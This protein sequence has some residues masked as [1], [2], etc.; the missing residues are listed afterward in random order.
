MEKK[1]SIWNYNP[2][3]TLFGFGNFNRTILGR[4][5]FSSRTSQFSF[6]S[7]G[8]TLIELVIVV[9]ILGVLAGLLVFVVNPG[10]QFAKA[11]D[12]QR[13]HDLDQVRNA[14]DTYYNDNNSYPL[15]Q[16]LGDCIIAGNAWGSSW[17]PYI[18]K[19]PKDPLS[20]RSYCYETSANGSYFWLFATLE[21]CSDFQGAIGVD[22]QR[23]GP[24]MQNYSINSSNIA[25][26]AP[27]P[28]PNPFPVYAA[29]WGSL[30]SGPGQLNSPYGVAVDASGNNI[31]VAD[32]RN[33]RIQKITAGGLGQWGTGYGQF[34]SPYGV[35][36]DANGNVYVADT[37]NNRIQ[38]FN[39][40]G[41]YIT[42]WGVYYP[43]GVAVDS[44]GNVYV[45]ETYNCRI[46]KFT[47]SGVFVTQW[48]TCGSGT[49]QFYYPYGVAVD[50]TGN[51]VYIAD[52][53]NNRIQKFTS[54]GGYIT[55]WGKSG[56]GSNPGLYL[57]HP[58]GVAVDSAG[59][60]YVAN[61]NDN[62]I[63][64]YNSSGGYITMWGSSGSGNGQLNQPSGVAVDLAG[65]VYVADTGNNRVQKFSP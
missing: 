7:K 33:Y 8:F 20:T 31:Y 42:M 36:V 11:R 18:R 50:S 6:L 12:V 13:K 35:A 61:T 27:R 44:A 45:V 49:V 9:A 40:S 53:Y 30:G 5:N 23:T 52:T 59:N 1:K 63:Q 56:S 15:N 57:N 62:H 38:K 65:N 22:C 60:V 47:S 46:K 4:K 41:G 43:S 19:L 55:V 17:D 2:L 64:K 48:G 24:R 14:L 58:F 21:R 3:R 54:S 26:V 29:Q 16:T 51:N 32:T 39:S 34:N 37:Y 10:A 25:A 28:T